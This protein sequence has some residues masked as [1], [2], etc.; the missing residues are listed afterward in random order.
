MVTGEKAGSGQFDG[1]TGL[2]FKADQEAATFESKY[3]EVDQTKSQLTLTGNVS[4]VGRNPEA[5]MRCERLVYDA[6][7]KVIRAL[8]NVR[9]TGKNGTLGPLSELLATPDLKTV[10]TPDMF[11]QP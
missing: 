4:V 7:A 9:V 11:K 5:T 1:V 8:G 2:L 6:N 10:A 3:G